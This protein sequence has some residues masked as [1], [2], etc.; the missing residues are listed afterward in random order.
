MFQEERTCLRPLPLEG[1]RYYTECE[2]T[3]YYL[4]SFKTRKGQR[5]QLSAI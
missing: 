4:T 3:R 2:R 1:F 5:Y